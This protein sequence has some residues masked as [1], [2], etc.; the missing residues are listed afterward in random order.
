MATYKGTKLFAKPI[1]PG[2]GSLLTPKEVAYAMPISL[3][4]A[5]YVVGGVFNGVID[6]NIDGQA[7]ANLMPGGIAGIQILNVPSVGAPGFILNTTAVFND[8]GWSVNCPVNRSVSAPVYTA[9][10]SFQFYWSANANPVASV[11]KMVLLN[12]RV[13]PF[14]QVYDA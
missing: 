8:T 6:I 12:Q 5:D 11:I 4:L 7:A 14:T 9:L 1:Y 10:N 3:P 2:I 13:A